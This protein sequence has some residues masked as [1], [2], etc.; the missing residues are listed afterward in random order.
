MEEFPGFGRG[1]LAGKERNRQLVF[2]LIVDGGPLVSQVHFCC[3]EKGNVMAAH[4]KTDY[5]VFGGRIFVQ[6][7]V[8]VRV[9]G[10][11]ESGI[12]FEGVERKFV[13]Q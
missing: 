6:P 5:G 3:G 4:V 9:V 2:G 8:S 7:G 11:R 13:L 10:V 12:E 1:H